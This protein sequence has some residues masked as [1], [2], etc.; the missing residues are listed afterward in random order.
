M[1][2]ATQ[3]F[4][5]TAQYT[6]SCSVACLALQLLHTLT[7]IMAQ[8]LSW[9]KQTLPFLNVTWLA[10]QHRKWSGLK[11]ADVC[12]LRV[13]FKMESWRFSTSHRKMRVSTDAPRQ[14]ASVQPV[15]RRLLKCSSSS[16]NPRKSRLLLREV[17]SRL[18]AKP[19]GP[20]HLT[21][22]GQSPTVNFQLK[23]TRFL[24][25]EQCGWKKSKLETREDTSAQWSFGRLNSKQK[26]R[27]MSRVRIDR[28]TTPL[29]LA[30]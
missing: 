18:A 17:M 25:T 4:I 10:S 14:T 23:G 19:L 22:R 29:F 30:S 12:L 26:C 24:L 9:K 20:R 8:H 7:S 21:S 11:L 6:N 1:T 5:Q 16:S 28:T 15:P 27:C 2:R 3:S 13:L